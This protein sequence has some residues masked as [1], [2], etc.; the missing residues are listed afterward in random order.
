MDEKAFQMFFLQS[1]VYHT[2]VFFII[3]LNKIIN[4]LLVGSD[5]SSRQF[6]KEQVQCFSQCKSLLIGTGRRIRAVCDNFEGLG[7]VGTKERHG[8]I[9]LECIPLQEN[10]WQGFT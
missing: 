8:C 9:M 2:P 10:S 5:G 1:T 6:F 4:P 3:P 7:R